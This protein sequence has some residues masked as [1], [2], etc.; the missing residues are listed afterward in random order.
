MS[1][2]PI[3]LPPNTIRSRRPAQYSHASLKH[4]AKPRK[5][6]HKPLHDAHPA[7]PS[8]QPVSGNIPRF[9]SRRRTVSAAAEE[10]LVDLLL[11]R[12]PRYR[13][14][15]T[16]LNQSRQ[17]DGFVEVL[18]KGFMVSMR[19]GE[20]SRFFVSHP[21]RRGSKVM[22]PENEA[23]IDKVVERV[24]GISCHGGR[25]M[26]NEEMGSG[27]SYGYGF[28]WTC[29]KDIYVRARVMGNSF[30]GGMEVTVKGPCKRKNSL[31]EEECGECGDSICGLCEKT[32]EC[33]ETN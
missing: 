12:K 30:G 27:L 21:L 13:T 10:H 11:N 19:H 16:K 22:S 31:V 28:Y 3:I 8:F 17:K 18:W 4:G 23:K 25:G 20:D 7:A 6:R 26:P 9:Q 29:C 32:A 24:T 1:A 5:S 33:A 14:T 15:P 2:L